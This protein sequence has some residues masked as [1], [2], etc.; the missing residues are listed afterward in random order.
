MEKDTE[1]LYNKLR[2]M[3]NDKYKLIDLI[4]K[5]R[6]N[7]TVNDTRL[8]SLLN[9]YG[10]SPSMLVDYNTGYWK[11]FA[12]G[13]KGGYLELYYWLQKKNGSKDSIVYM[14]DSIL[15]KDPELQKIIGFKTIFKRPDTS[16]SDVSIRGTRP[17]RNT[18]YVKS[19]S[20]IVRELVAQEDKSL[21]Y[22]FVSDYEIGLSEQ[23][24]R[25]KYNNATTLGVKKSDLESFESM[26]DSILKGEGTDDLPVHSD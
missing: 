23:E 17:S 21:F 25:E 2:V 1:L 22:S 10:D 24:L 16:K 13:K 4:R 12:T 7:T 3:I 26:L 18:S 19:F 14:A 9:D 8:I 6:P 5:V 11:C 15:R 20:R